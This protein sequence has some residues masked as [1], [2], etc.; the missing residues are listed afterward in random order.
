[1]LVPLLTVSALTLAASPDPLTSAR[2]E[3]QALVLVQQTLQWYTATVGEPSI[4]A[5][6]YLGHD[7]LFSKETIARVR[8]SAKQPGISADERRAREYLQAYLAGEF[9]S[10]STSK[11]DDRAQNA[12]LRATVRLPWLQDPVP[13][14][15]LDLLVAE[16]KDAGRRAAIEKARSE[17]ARTVLNPILEQKEATA[18]RLARELGYRSYVELSEEG[19]R[20]QLRPFM[21]EGKRF[22]DATDGIFH[23]LLREIASRELGISVAQL[24]RSD[25]SRMFKAPRHERFFPAEI[26]VPSF[27]AFL[28]GMGIDF[29]TVAGTEVRVDDSVN[30][31]KEPRAACW[32]IRVPSDVRINVKPIP[33]LDSL[34]VFFHE[35]GHA[36]MFA[37]TTTKVWEFQQLGPGAFTEGLGELFRYS[38]ADPVWLRRYRSFVQAHNAE[39][40]RN[41]PLMSDQDIRELSRLQ[42]LY[43][44]NYLRRYAYAKLVYE[45]V[46]HG[47]SPSLWKDL[48]D[49]PTTDPMTVYRELFSTAYGVPL[50]ETDALRFRT[51]VDD[52]FYSLDYARSF[53]LAHLMSEG[54]RAKFGPDWYGSLEAGR[55]IRILVADGNK[56]EAEDV[57]KVFG[58]PFDLRPAEARIRR[59]LAE[60]AGQ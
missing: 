12:A 47:G 16:E 55:L 30:P 13:Y 37:N 9:L 8:K 2:A 1:M 40:K 56:T 11:F 24:R 5:E 32:G 3:A 43:Q 59:L 54:M 21:V 51:D 4:Q 14:K 26:V 25:L 50:D 28:G 53:A 60:T 23:E 34:G 44:L 48:Y 52:T 22:L 18:R 45:S 42:L 15:Q 38:W 33:G 49:R 7:R 41:D 31:L 36:V 58:I 29:K 46:L 57:A 20:A 17:V 27:R 6:T 10:Q 19:R 35:G 39:S